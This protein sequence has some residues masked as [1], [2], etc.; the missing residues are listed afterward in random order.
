MPGHALRVRQLHARGQHALY[1]RTLLAGRN[2]GA[3]RAHQPGEI[4]APGGHRQRGEVRA[5]EVPRPLH[6]PAGEGAGR[7][8]DHH[9]HR[10]R[11]RTAPG[12]ER[13][14]DAKDATEGVKAALPFGVSSPES[15]REASRAALSDGGVE[16]VENVSTLDGVAGLCL[17]GGADVDPAL[18]GEAR[19]P[20]TQEPDPDR[21]RLENALLREAVDPDV[22]VLAIC[23]GL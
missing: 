1:A 3:G 20:E 9:R 14:P 16:P 22:P 7:P 4:R 18:Y 8:G 11:R 23:P 12:P 6:G 19:W 21:D 13:D 17:A 2:R 5:G 15:K 10:M